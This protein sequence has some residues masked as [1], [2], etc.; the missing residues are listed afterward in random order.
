MSKKRDKEIQRQRAKAKKREKRLRREKRQNEK[1]E[2]QKKRPPKV[3]ST[4]K[5]NV[6]TTFSRSAWQPPGNAQQAALAD[7][8]LGRTAKPK[9]G[10]NKEAW[11]PN[12][13][14]AIRPSVTTP[15]GFNAEA[16]KPQ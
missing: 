16:W 8:V 7:R 2:R 10:F 1:R 12:P 15:N 9:I 5:S 13:D 11:Q 14:T 6:V 4:Q 3:H